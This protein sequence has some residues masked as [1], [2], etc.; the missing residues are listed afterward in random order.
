MVVTS[1]Y[2]G[3]SISLEKLTIFVTLFGKIDLITHDSK[4]D[5][6]HHECYPA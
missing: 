3:F 2:K 6:F 4:F 1:G 5:F